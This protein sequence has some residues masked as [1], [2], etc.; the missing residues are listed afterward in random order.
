MKKRFFLLLSFCLVQAVL[1]G[2]GQKNILAST[3]WIAAYLQLAGAE[4][5]ETLA[6]AT[7]LH[8]AEYEL[9]LLDMK[10]VRNASAIVYSGYEVMAPKI[11]ESIKGTGVKSIKVKTSYIYSE[12]EKEVM[13]I[14]SE[15]GDT[16][17]ARKNLKQLKS[18]FDDGRKQVEQ[19]G[20]KG[21]PV[22][23]HF[24]QQQIV[25]ELGLVAVG[26][27]GP[28]P[29][30]AFQIKKLAGS[31]ARFIVDNYHNPVAQPLTEALKLKTAQLINF[32]GQDGTVSLEDVVRRNCAVICA[33]FK[34]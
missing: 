33:S 18:A 15:I 4:N 26:V 24:F 12:I 9:T 22:L 19:A 13:A 3:S 14:A 16:S 28:A 34:P 7:M 31:K 8:P 29:V 17:V 11:V 10:K 1:F 2:Q 5:V 30:E 21:Q 20:L 6:P 27:F 25:S 32:P 23:V